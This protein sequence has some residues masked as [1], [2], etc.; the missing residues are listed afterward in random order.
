MHTPS[1]TTWGQGEGQ[2]DTA[3]DILGPGNEQRTHS[4]QHLLMGYFTN[5]NRIHI[6]VIFFLC[7]APTLARPGRLSQYQEGNYREQLDARSALK[8]RA[9]R[10]T[11]FHFLSRGSQIRNNQNPAGNN[12]W[13][14]NWV[15]CTTD[16]SNVS[17]SRSFSDCF[18]FPLILKIAA[19]S[20]FTFSTSP[21]LQTP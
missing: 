11:Y 21:L 13:H 6:G 9:Q 14:L 7:V 8:S 15:G 5:K 10:F 16:V 3:K 17:L 4:A 2:Q 20:W 18:F 1:L 19:L 12:I